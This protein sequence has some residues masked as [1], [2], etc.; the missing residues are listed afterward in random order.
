M[1]STI[2]GSQSVTMPA[3]TTG[4]RPTAASA[5]MRYNTTLGVMED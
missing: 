1:P 3:D 4:N 2:L 5:M